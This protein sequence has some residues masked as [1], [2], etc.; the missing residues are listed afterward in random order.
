[1]PRRF[2][3]Q[4]CVPATSSS[5]TISQLIRRWQHVK[6]SK[7][8]GRVCCSFRHT[9]PTSIQSKTPSQHSRPSYERPPPEPSPSYEI[10]RASCRER[11]CQ[12][13]SISG[14]VVS[15]KKKK[16]DHTKNT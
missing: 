1:M 11:G 15:L 2:W 5:S 3:R 8:P 9:V 14:V 10:G 7:R 4:R 6:P 12:Y 13:V 16:K